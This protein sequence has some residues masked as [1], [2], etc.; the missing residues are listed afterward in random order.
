MNEI[1]IAIAASMIVAAPVLAQTTPQPTSS[2][3]APAAVAP[4]TTKL[5]LEVLMANPAARDVV[6]GVFPKL[7]ENPLYESLKSKSL[8]EIAPMAGG[9]ITDEQLDR[10]DAGLRALK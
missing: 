5:P 9:T 1:T 2:P 4:L 3:A 8:R 10:V 7:D 6:L